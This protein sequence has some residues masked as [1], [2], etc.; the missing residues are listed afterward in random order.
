MLRNKKLYFWLFVL[1]SSIAVFVFAGSEQ[2]LAMDVNME[3]VMLILAFVAWPL[4]YLITVY[5][6]KKKPLYLL[7]PMSIGVILGSFVIPTEEKSLWTYF[8]FVR[9]LVIPFL[10][11]FE[12][13]VLYLV[14]KTYRRLSQKDTVEDDLKKEIE[15]IIGDGVGSKI[16]MVELLMWY[17]ALL[18]WRKNPFNY[19]GEKHFTYHKKDD[20]ATTQ[21]GFLFVIGL[22]IIPMHFLLHF[23][24]SPTAA[25]V[26]TALTVYSWLWLYGEYKATMLRP[27]S[28]DDEKLI[29]RFGLLG[30]EEV[31]YSSISK[32][33]VVDGKVG[34]RKDIIRHKGNSAPNL[35]VVLK[36]GA[37]LENAFGIVKPYRAVY[38]AVDAPTQLKEALEERLMIH[39]FQSKVTM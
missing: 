28:M 6:S 29:I 1:V 33:L 22:E 17:Y 9:Y 3:K 14:I 19:A 20:Y 26:I 8:E 10:V 4:L 7:V 11:L 34:R 21:I 38:L 31:P 39:P 35:Q 30:N 16:L 18:S 2:Q 37:K 12:V 15:E 13:Y 5:P 23:I 25:T 27:I 32:V 24:W 36:P